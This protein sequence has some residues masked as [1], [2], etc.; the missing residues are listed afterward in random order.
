M[1]NP[2]FFYLARAAIGKLMCLFRNT[3]SAART[4][5]ASQH[6]RDSLPKSAKRWLSVLLDNGACETQLGGVA[7]RKPVDA[8]YLLTLPISPSSRS[9]AISLITISF[10]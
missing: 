7:Y 6:P 10:M 4:A 1:G 2:E 5:F 8:K 9:R 3:Y